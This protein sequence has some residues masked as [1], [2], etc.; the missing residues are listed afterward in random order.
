MVQALDHE[1]S[2]VVFMHMGGKVQ[3]FSPDLEK[4]F[5]MKILFTRPNVLGFWVGECVFEIFD[6]GV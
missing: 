6:P 4:K 5:T 3:D 2:S 1:G